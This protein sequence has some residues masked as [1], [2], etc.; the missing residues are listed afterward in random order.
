MKELESTTNP[1]PNLKESTMRNF[2]RAYKQKLDF[3]RKQ[4][5]PKPVS[6]ISTQAKGALT[7]F[8]GT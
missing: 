3:Q 6:D 1:F 7:N 2:K 8:V 5:N 4:T